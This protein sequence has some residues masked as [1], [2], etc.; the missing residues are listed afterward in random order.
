[1]ENEEQLKIVVREA[2]GSAVKETLLSLGIDPTDAIKTQQHMHALREVSYMLDDEEFKADLLH[3][4]KWRKSMDQV[5]NVGIKTAVG[6]VVTGFFGMI[7]FAFKT[8][9]GK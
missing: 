6:I 5:S 8:W 4:R 9:L 1:M 3:L 7:V 2:V